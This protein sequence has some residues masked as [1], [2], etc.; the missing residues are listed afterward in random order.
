MSERGA[1]GTDACCGPSVVWESRTGGVIVLALT[2]IRFAFA[3]CLVAS[4]FLVDSDPRSGLAK[5]NPHPP[6]GKA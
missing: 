4:I 5:Y 1:R 2:E 3:I 6:N